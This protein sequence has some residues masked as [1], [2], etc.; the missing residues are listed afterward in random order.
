MALTCDTTLSLYRATT[1]LEFAFY[2]DGWKVQDSSPSNKYEVQSAQL[3]DSG[4]YTCNVKTMIS[5]TM[6]LSDGYNIRVQE[7]FSPPVLK[8]SPELVNDGDIITLICDT[9]LTEPRWSTELQYVFY[10]D[11]ERVQGFSSDNKYEV[12]FIPEEHSGTYTC[13]I[14][15]PNSKIKKRS[16]DLHVQESKDSSLVIII[17]G[18]LGLLLLIVIIFIVL[19]IYY[20][21]RSSNKNPQPTTAT[22]NEDSTEVHVTDTDIDMIS[23]PQTATSED[24]TDVPVTYSVLNMTNKTQ[25]HLPKDNEPNVVYAVVNP[26]TKRKAKESQET[27]ETATEIYQNINCPR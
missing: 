23:R 20:R 6:K 10:R 4:N 24:P 15:T 13:E 25:N 11:G 2:R 21:R 5:S 1:R 27:S 17:A 8:V 16:Q 3:E 14:Q 9:N 19:Y 22:D 7:L 26:K 12:Q 18:S